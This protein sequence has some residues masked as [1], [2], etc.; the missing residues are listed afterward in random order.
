MEVRPP[1]DIAVE[2]IYRSLTYPS[3]LQF[4]SFAQEPRASELITLIG[5]FFLQQCVCGIRL[6]TSSFLRF[7]WRLS[8]T[9][10]G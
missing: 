9:P 2:A 7:Q 10:I 3:A 8:K 4:L 1:T 6:D 5:R